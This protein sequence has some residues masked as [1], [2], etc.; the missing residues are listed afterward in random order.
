MDNSKIYLVRSPSKLITD[1]LAG[2]G[3]PQVNFSQAQ[4]A[5]GLMA[6]FADKGINPGRQRNQ[7]KR[8]F[9]IQEGDLVV[10]PLH[11]AAAFGIATGKRSYATGVGY[12]ENR[13]G[14]EYF[15]HED[16]SV[17][18]VPR[19]ELPEALS[20]RLKIR[21][22]VVSLDE[23]KD[24]ITRI[25]NQIQDKGAASF[26]SHIQQLEA[27]ALTTLREQ[28]LNN[29][30]SGKT[31][32]E[33]GGI[34]LEKLVAELLRTEGYAA[35]ILAK[36]AFEGNAD[37]DIEAFREDRFTSNKLLIQVKHHTGN[38]GHHA[39]RQLQLLDKEDDVQRWLITTGDVQQ[40][41]VEEAEGQGIGVMD[42]DR[43]VE[44]VVE[45]ADQL[46]QRTLNRLGLS[47]TPSLLV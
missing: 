16:G 12:G 5:V 2:Y 38:T 13:I 36:T 28:L 32:L 10:V 11:R 46:S 43:F 8:F 21:M 26:D 6:L 37:A 19:S 15:R 42:G 3:W 45:R 25:I 17:V 31:T 1:N 4:D 7:I 27:D 39:L 34:G 22:S 20:T 23:F 40:E 9:S 44:W 47:T 33:S 41:M 14:V 30:R 18:R 29:L 24:D 35:K